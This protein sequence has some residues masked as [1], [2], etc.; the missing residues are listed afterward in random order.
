VPS[1][2]LDASITLD[3]EILIEA[4]SL[5]SRLLE[6]QH[7]SERAQADYHH[8]I[9]RL[10]V[11]GGSLREIAA[12]LGLSHQR[13]HQIVGADAPGELP[14]RRQGRGPFLRFTRVAR[15]VVV[16]AQ[17]EAR[18]LGHGR[19]GTEHLLVSSARVERGGAARVLADAGVTAEALRE[20]VAGAVPAGE[21]SRRKRLPFTRAAKRSLEQAL[22][23]ASQLRSGAIGSEHL[24]L[25]LLATDDGGALEILTSIADPA[26]LRDGALAALDASR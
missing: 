26:A 22:G 2:T 11:A 21:P 6:L 10:Q 12:E 25:G 5:R 7:D 23:E 4:R 14:R 16:A 20:A 3:E 15:E 19:V 8:A 18:A 24:L 13:V 17:D 1:T 9:R